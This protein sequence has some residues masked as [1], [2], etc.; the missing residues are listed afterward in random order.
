MALLDQEIADVTSL[1]GG[2]VFIGGRYHSL[3][4]ILQDI[5][6]GN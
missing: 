3:L 4:P 1:D 6:E 5:Y 2:D